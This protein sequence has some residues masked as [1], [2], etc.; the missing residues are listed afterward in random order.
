MNIK[1]VVVGK[2]LN[3]T[4]II[5]TKE[6]NAVII[7]P[8]IEFD[9]IEKAL[10]ESG[11][12]LKYLI[13]TH[14]H[15]DHTASAYDLVKK[16]GAKLVIA[17][18]DA[19]MLEDTDKSMSWM[20]TNHPHSLKADIEVEDGDTLSLDEL[21]FEFLLTPGH[22]KGSMVILCEDVMFSGDTV[23]ECSVGRT[24]FYGGNEAFM[25]QS[26]KRLAQLSKNYRILAGHGEETT[27]EKEKQQ[28]PYFIQY[29]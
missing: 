4:Y 26:V 19:E 13:F 17:A 18:R 14:G 27:L 12:S 3:N 16:T 15:Y 28:N 1:T 9:K 8:G 2:L 5:T 10:D 22:S 11:A 7:D 24:D 6:N 20:F 21:T 23:L 25:I 29:A